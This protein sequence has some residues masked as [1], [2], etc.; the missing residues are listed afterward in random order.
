MVADKILNVHKISL[1][2][3][4]KKR[5]QT[6]KKHIYTYMYILHPQK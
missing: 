5:F 3:V 4:G 1:S 6:K 2:N